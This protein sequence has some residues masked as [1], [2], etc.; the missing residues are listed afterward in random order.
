MA[1]LVQMEGD[2][3]MATTIHPEDTTGGLIAASK[4]TGTS[5]YDLAGEKLGS[6]Y[7][8]MIDK[9]SGT[10]KYAVMNFGGLFGIGER[11]H[12]L[13]WNVLKYDADRGGYVVNIDR[14]SLEAAPSYETGDTSLWGEDTWGGR[15]NEYYGRPSQNDIAFGSSAG[16][17][18]GGRMPII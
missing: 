10:T 18:L 1:D 5:V 11:Y 13:P 6:I 15:V 12:P 3:Y 7:D 8:V 2:F 14:G 4:V 17:P 9:S 16:L